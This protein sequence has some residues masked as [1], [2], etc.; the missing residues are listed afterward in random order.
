MEIAYSGLWDPGSA[1]S[2]WLHWYHMKLL[3]YFPSSLSEGNVAKSKM[4]NGNSELSK[5][6]LGSNI[7]DR[8][9]HKLNTHTLLNAHEN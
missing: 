6:G 8:Q 7:N 9:N 1:C 2:L 5:S 3:N 4:A